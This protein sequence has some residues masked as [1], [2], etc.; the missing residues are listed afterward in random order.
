MGPRA[1]DVT[2]KVLLSGASLAVVSCAS[3][4]NAPPPAEATSSV[5]FVEGVPGGIYVQRVNAVADVVFVD[6]AE[7]KVSF[8]TSDGKKTTVTAGPE[9]ANF[10]QIRVGDRLRLAIAEEL[11]VRMADSAAPYAPVEGS[12]A[13]I[14]LAPIGAK[15]A[16]L[17][18][19]AMQYTAVIT[20]LDHEKHQATLRFP[21]GVSRTLPV[22]PDVDLARRRVGEQVSIRSTVAAA[23]E[24]GPR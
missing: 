8:R 24:V 14:A 7:R 17:M 19:D 11:I 1:F 20:S 9:V 2:L 15:P 16:L 13:V 21:D 4:S 18:A 22:R 6:K 12:A 5:V 10:D 3:T 23:I